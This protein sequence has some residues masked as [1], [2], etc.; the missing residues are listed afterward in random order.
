MPFES[1]PVITIQS[2]PAHVRYVDSGSLTRP[3]FVI[4][5][6]PGPVGHG[7]PGQI[8]PFPSKNMTR[9][10]KSE[11]SFLP[12]KSMNLP[13]GGLWTQEDD[14]PPQ[15]H[16]YNLYLGVK[17]DKKTLLTIASQG[18]PYHDDSVRKK[19]FEQPPHVL[20]KEERV[21]QSPPISSSA[22]AFTTLLNGKLVFINEWE[23]DGIRF[24]SVEFNHNPDGTKPM[25]P[26]HITFESPVSQYKK[27]IASIKKCLSTIVWIDKIDIPVP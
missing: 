22:N 20:T 9:L 12:M 23:R 16:S 24:Y 17:N 5:K 14:D 26:A 2:P 6:A 3:R 13:A 1:P 7:S 8:S 11:L 10:L 27:R 19:L 21:A 15:T 18:F 4:S 25:I